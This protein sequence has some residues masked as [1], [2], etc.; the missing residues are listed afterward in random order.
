M[1]DFLL[2]KGHT[3]R[4]IVR[5]KSGTRFLDGKPVEIH[6]CGLEDAE[7]LKKVFEGASY[8]FH[9]AGATRARKYE[10][11]YQSNVVA[12]QN[13]LEAALHTPTIKRVLLTS[14]LAANGS[15]VPGVLLTED[16][17]YNPNTRYGRSK[18]E[19]ELMAQKYF[20]RVPCTVVRPPAVYGEREYGILQFFQLVNK[21]FITL[22]GMKTKTMSLV[23]SADLVRAMYM[24]ALSDNT[25]GEAYFISGP[26]EYSWQEVADGIGHYLGKKPRKIHI[27][28]FIAKG[29]AGIADFV[30]GIIGKDID[31]TY[32]RAHQ[33][34]QPAWICNPDKARRDFGFE[35]EFPLEKAVPRIA[36]WYRA[37]KLL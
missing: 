19:L 23:Y 36:E 10:G 13:V 32:E 1:V 3:V 20:D 2:E 7:A 9:I 35:E 8:V 31:L 5:G 11:Y 16:A 29:A 37:E 18:M 26:K 17:P 25:I 14:S 34:S 12:T 33:M 15:S 30:S 21:G 6:R 22:L 4:C 27:P 24:A 28:H